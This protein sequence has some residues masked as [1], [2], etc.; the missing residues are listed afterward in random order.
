MINIALAQLNPIIGDFQGNCEKA[1]KAAWESHSQGAQLTI[2]PESFITGYQPLDLLFVE[3][4]VENAL[5]ALKELLPKLPPTTF[6]IGLPTKNHKPFGKPLY[7]SVAVISKNK[8]VNFHHKKLLPTY[9]VFDEARYFVPGKIH[10]T[11]VDGTKI[12][13]LICEDMWSECTIDGRRL[14]LETPIHTLKEAQPDLVVVISASPFLPQKQI[15]REEILKEIAQTVQ[16]PVASVNQ[17]GGNDGLLFDGGSCYVTPDGAVLRNVSFEEK[18]F[19]INPQTASHD[20]LPPDVE[21]EKALVMGIR[22]FFHKQGF[23]KALIGLSGGIDSSVVAYLACKAL[24]PENVLG[25]LLPSRFTTKESIHDAMQL[26]QNLHIETRTISIEKPLQGFLETLDYQ[27]KEIDIPFENL[28][29]RTRGNILMT[30]SNAERRLLLATSNKSEIAVGYFT[31]YGDA[32]GAIAPIGDLFKT[33]VY[34][35]ALHLNMKKEII[36]KSIL[37]KAPTAEL[38]PNQKDEDSIPH[39]SILDP[40]LEELILNK[41]SPQATAEYLNMPV[42]LVVDVFTKL[43]SAEFKRKQSAPVLRVSQQAFNLGRLMPI[44]ERY[45][46]K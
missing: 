23:S 41:A 34:K 9:D 1:L 12:G 17:V 30:I 44:V 40:I 4:F 28:Q 33:E 11:E 5:Q 46:S 43:K 27:P 14:Y 8:I 38:R 20:L 2:F 31:L 45:Q 24:G 10:C 7:N 22:D 19:F 15:V 18:V 3:D 13:I 42:E 29:A 35:L 16:C 39:Y 32:C 21:I 26:A 6:L 37:T 25:V 36:P